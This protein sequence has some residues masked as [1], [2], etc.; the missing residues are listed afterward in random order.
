[1]KLNNP[2]SFN[3]KYIVKATGNQ[4]DAYDG[5]KL[6]GLKF[7]QLEDIGTPSG[8]KV[9]ITNPN[10]DG[11]DY[12]DMNFNAVKEIDITNQD[13]NII[14]WNENIC[15]VEHN[16]N[17]YVFIQVYDEDGDEIPLVKT[18]IDENHISAYFESK[19]GN[20]ETY[21]MVCLS[22]GY[23]LNDLEINK[24]SLASCSNLGFF[25]DG[26]KLA[27]SW[28]DPDDVV[29][30]GATL[31]TWDKTVLVRKEGSYPENHTDGTIIASTSR[32]GQTKNYYRDHSYIETEQGNYFYML[33]SNTTAG[34]WNNLTAN[35]FTNGTGLTW[36]QVGDFVDAGRGAELFPVGTTFIVDHAEYT[37]STGIQGIAFT[38]LGHDQVPCADETLSHNMCLGMSEIIFNAQYDANELTY[39]LTND[40]VAK[41]NKTYY[42]YDNST[43]IQLV[44]GTDY[45]VGDNVPV[46]TYYEKNLI[47]RHSGSNNFAES[48]L[49]Q[50]ANSNGS[51]GEWFVKQNIWDTCGTILNGKNGFL[52]CLDSNFL[53]VVKEAELTTNTYK[54][55]SF[56]TMSAKF[57]LLSLTQVFGT[58]NGGIQENEQ[59]TYFINTNNRIKKLNGNNNSWMLRSNLPGFNHQSMIVT[60]TGESTYSYSHGLRGISLAC[61]IG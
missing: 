44:E 6:T 9:L 59:L 55:I 51:A 3:G 33:F 19:P 15:V 1:M 46:A 49:L 8:N 25:I 4:I 32:I 26:T 43:Y 61:I 42:I 35:K 41:A 38:V 10:G 58:N 14:T 22:G 5:S 2:T 34:V 31:A 27:F 23:S 47:N 28:T 17:G 24:I 52:K 12:I 56:Q 30:N 7:T 29:L 57:W 54:G 36:Q 60:I 37:T 53:S 48:N 45:N 21:K 20:G 39:V 13:S 18:H 11:L 40:T 16:M 50:W